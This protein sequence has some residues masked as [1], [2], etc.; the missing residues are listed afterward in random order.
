MFW[1]LELLKLHILSLQDSSFI[2]C[3]LNL[4]VHCYCGFQYKEPILFYIDFFEICCSNILLH[5]G[6]HHDMFLV[7]HSSSQVKSHICQ[8][9]SNNFIYCIAK[10]FT[11]L[12]N[13]VILHFLEVTILRLIIVFA[14]LRHSVH[15]AKIASSLYPQ[16]IS[17]VITASSMISYVLVPNDSLAFKFC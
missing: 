8:S 14:L 13:D 2:D 12:A 17:F 11:S 1:C 6:N 7:Y 10:L 5:S 9:W 15:A 16:R 3:H 4:Q